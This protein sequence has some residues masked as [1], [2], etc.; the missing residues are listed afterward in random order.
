MDAIR[1]TLTDIAWLICRAA[2]AL[3]SRRASVRISRRLAT[4]VGP[5]SA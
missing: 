5:T 1:S 3:N 2:I 4:F